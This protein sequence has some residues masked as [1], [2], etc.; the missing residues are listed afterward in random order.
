MATARPSLHPVVPPEAT[1]FEKLDAMT[2]TQLRH[3]VDGCPAM[4]D[5]LWRDAPDA[6]GW[7]HTFANPG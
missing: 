1:G 2:G 5:G 3:V 7:R 6:R 4:A